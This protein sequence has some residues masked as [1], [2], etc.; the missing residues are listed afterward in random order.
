MKQTWTLAWQRTN[1]S[2]HCFLLKTAHKFKATMGW[3]RDY[4]IYK[5]HW[6]TSWLFKLSRLPLGGEWGTCPC[7]ILCPFGSLVKVLTNRWKITSVKEWWRHNKMTSYHHLM[8]MRRDLFPPDSRFIQILI[9]GTCKF[10]Q[11]HAIIML[12]YYFFYSLS[13]EFSTNPRCSST[14]LPS[15]GPG[16]ILLFTDVSARSEPSSGGRMH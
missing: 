14:S 7:D 1:F 8:F 12:V 2:I 16:F 6:A 10:M 11:V 3:I 15:V 9:T 4:R 5:S 13:R